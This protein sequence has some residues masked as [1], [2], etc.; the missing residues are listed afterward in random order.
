LLNGITYLQ[1]PIA[2]TAEECRE[3]ERLVRRG[4]DGSDESLPDRIQ[5]AS[6]LAFYNVARG[7]LAAIAAL[8]VPDE[9]YRD[10]IFRKADAGVS[11]DNYKLELG[12]V[13]VGPAYRGN[14]IAGSIC[15][16]LL[17]SVPESSVFATTHPNNTVMIRILAAFDFV[18]AGKPF[19]RRSQEL[20]LFL[21]TGPEC[22]VDRLTA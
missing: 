6:R 15:Q 12:W 17:E 7:T 1:E 5:R 19:P 4:F 11:T 13:F 2:C 20:V 14:H 10:D 16:L 18:R 3:F 9:R 22:G 21:R 8:K